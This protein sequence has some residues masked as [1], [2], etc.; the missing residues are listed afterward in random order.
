MLE[1]D[2]TQDSIE[3]VVREIANY[4]EYEPAC[5]VSRAKG[6]LRAVLTIIPK[7]FR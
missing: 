1:E 4:S 2:R 3:A 6:I 5:P 7:E